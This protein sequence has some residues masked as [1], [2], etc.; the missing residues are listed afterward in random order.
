M[1]QH[2][3]QGGE[4]AVVHVRTGKR[5]VAQ[6]RRLEEPMIETVPGDRPDALVGVN[7]VEPIV[8]GE[9]QDLRTAQMTTRTA[10]R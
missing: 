3:L 10:K 2:V 5:H 1:L 4:P 9:N 6:R 7:H 8:T